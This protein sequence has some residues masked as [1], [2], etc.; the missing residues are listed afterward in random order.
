MFQDVKVG[1]GRSR[2]CWE[3]MK[4]YGDGVVGVRRWGWVVGS[5]SWGVEPH[6]WRY[7]SGSVNRGST[8]GFCSSVA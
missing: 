4:G 3:L 8:V 5:C 2:R 6:L 7:G 1:D